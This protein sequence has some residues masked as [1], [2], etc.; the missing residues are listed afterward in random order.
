MIPTRLCFKRRY[1]C[2][3]S[4]LLRFNGLSS[5]TIKHIESSEGHSTFIVPNGTMTKSRKEE[6]ELSS[7]KTCVQRDPSFDFEYCKWLR[8]DLALADGH[9]RAET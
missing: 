5:M 9:K 8:V 2:E 1:W 3:L 7:W 6:Y 4:L